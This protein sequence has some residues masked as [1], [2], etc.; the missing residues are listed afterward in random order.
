MRSKDFA[1]LEAAI[2]KWADTASIRADDQ[3][4]NGY[5]GNQT[6]PMM[7]I[8]ARAVF[9][10]CEEAQEYAEREGLLKRPA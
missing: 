3:L 9:D 8:A 4:M 7:A 5:I 1:D 6:I 10:A 2:Q